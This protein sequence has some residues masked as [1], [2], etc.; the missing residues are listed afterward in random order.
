MA[1]EFFKF[2]DQ[3]SRETSETCGTI[4]IF[5]NGKNWHL[6]SQFIK[7][8]PKFLKTILSVPGPGRNWLPKAGWAR[9]NTTHPGCPAAPSKLPKSGWAIAHSAH[10]PVTPLCP[11]QKIRWLR[12][13]SK[14]LIRIPVRQARYRVYQRKHL[15]FILLWRV[16][17]CKLPLVWRWFGNP[18]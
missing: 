8:C 18:E 3:N 12:N 17:I 5:A 9:S 16:E 10:P 14:F 6:V 4:R 1:A 13:S 2:N 15:Y 7:V 11:I